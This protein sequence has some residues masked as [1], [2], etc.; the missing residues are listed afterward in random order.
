MADKEHGALKQNGP[1]I[2]IEEEEL[3]QEEMMELYAKSM[4]NLEEGRVV[5]GSVVKL[6]PKEAIV[7]VGLKSE[8]IVPLSE[9]KRPEELSVGDEVEVFLEETEDDEG[10]AVLSKQKADFLRVWDNIKAAYDEGTPVEG[11][12][13]RRVRGGMIVDLLGVDAFLPGSQIDLHP[14]KDMDKLISSAYKFKIIKLNWKRRNIVVSRRAIL[15]EE[16]EEARAQ[17]LEELEVNQEREGIVKNITDFGAFVDLGGVDGLLH[18]TDMSWGRVIHPSELV[19]IGDKVKTKVIGIDREK[20]RV[21]LGMKQLTPY[22][23]ENI[24]EKYP[25]GSRVRGKVVSITDYG[26]FVELEKGVEGLIHI[27][28]MAWTR[29]I[30]HPSQVVAIGDVLDAVVLSTD[31]ENERISLGLKQTVPDPWETLEERHPAGSVLSGKVRTITNFGAFVE[32]E[33][34]IDGLVHISDM[35]WTRRISHPSEVVKRGEKVDVVVLSIDKENRRISLGMKQTEEDPLEEFINANEIGNEM[36]GKVAELLEQGLIVELGQEVRGFVPFSHLVRENM[37]VPADK[38]GV[39]EELSLVLIEVNTE[40]R[41]VI[42][43]EKAFYQA[44][45][46]VAEETEKNA[47]RPKKRRERRKG[48]RREREGEETFE[49]ESG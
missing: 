43:S 40:S 36:K 6:G 8:G 18:I 22:P 45:G 15:E 31:K 29:R 11:I 44:Q 41:R 38:Y 42:L 25:V 21:S 46:A 7:D 12:V 3:S 10:F 34:G 24:E 32:I 5:K 49:V 37:S 26:A 35:S 2:E 33:D 23:W 27:S 39:G 16:R 20:M 28:E 17:L 4:C 9:F 14:I 13:S 30:H 19:A 48:R 47:R 1:E